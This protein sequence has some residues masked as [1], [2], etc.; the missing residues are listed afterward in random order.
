[1]NTPI[2]PI[3]FTI[4]DAETPA[5]GLSLT[6]NSS[7]P[8]LVPKSNIVFGGS[9]ADR[10][11]T[12][13]P[14]LGQQGTAMITVIVTDAGGRSASD[15]FELTV[16]G[17]NMVNPGLVLADTFSYIDGSLITNSAFIWN[18]HSGKT[19][20]TQVVSGK[21][22][23]SG[24]QTED[25]NATLTNAPFATNGSVILYASFAVNFSQL[26]SGAGTYFAHFKDTGASN[27]RARVF[28]GTTNAAGGL[29]RLGIANASGAVSA[30]VTNDLSLNT[31]YTVVVRYNVGTAASTLWINPTSE[32]DSSATATD[33]TSLLAISTF[34]F[35]QSTGIGT[36][37][38]D[39][40]KVGASF[41]DVVTG[42]SAVRLQILS[43]G[44]SVEIS[45]PISA[46]GFVLQGT[47]TLASPNW[48]NVSFTQSGDRNVALV[49][50]NSRASFYRL[51]RTGP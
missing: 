40:L 22:Q 31:T 8:T 41:A 32:S 26:P 33:S 48:S 50:A 4:G 24:S 21:L 10:T 44:G 18:A 43:S 20:E 27:F 23:L 3:P 45:W 28:A 36:L 39:D 49:P 46:A 12:I 29:F 9:G 30:Q 25:V 13:T 38:V 47:A 35:R 11:V 14:A 17:A 16:I 42:A 7:N 37:A 15:T 19:G 34:A 51:I 2:G 1:M 5:A 6:N